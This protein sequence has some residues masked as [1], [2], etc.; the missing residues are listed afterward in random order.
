MTKEQAKEIL[1]QAINA[2]LIKGIY[3]LKDIRIILDAL[4]IVSEEK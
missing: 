1:E 2:A 3:S 4:S